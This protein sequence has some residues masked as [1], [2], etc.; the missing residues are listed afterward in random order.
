VSELTTCN[1]C[2]YEA[3]K[4]RAKERGVWVILRGQ[5]DWISA[6][7]SDEELPSAFFMEL[8]E[9]CVC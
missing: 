1:Y 2:N 4:K 6:R 3:M 7:Y 5:D 8:T 9:S